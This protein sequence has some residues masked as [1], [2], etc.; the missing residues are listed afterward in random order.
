MEP[1]QTDDKLLVR[2]KKVPQIQKE[3]TKNRNQETTQDC[4]STKIHVHN[5]SHRKQERQ[6][7]RYFELYPYLAIDSIRGGRIWSSFS[8]C[9]I[10]T[11]TRQQLPPKDTA[12]T[13]TLVHFYTP[14]KQNASTPTSNTSFLLLIEQTATPCHLLAGTHIHAYA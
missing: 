14:H 1:N 9:P 8:T 13:Q 2:N 5:G 7:A 12:N 4:T 6:Q 11:H 3:T 10:P